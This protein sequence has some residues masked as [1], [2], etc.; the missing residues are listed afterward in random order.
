[1]WSLFGPVSK[2]TYYRHRNV[3][4]S[5]LQNRADENKEPDTSDI[6][7]LLDIESDH[8][9]DRSEMENIDLDQ[10]EYLFE[11]ALVMEDPHTDSD[12]DAVNDNHLVPFDMRPIS[13]AIPNAASVAEVSLALI[14]L[15]RKF[16]ISVAA[17]RCFSEL[18][19]IATGEG[20]R[21]PTFT[22]ARAVQEDSDVNY[23]VVDCCV[24]DDCVFENAPKHCDPN[25]LRQHRDLRKC[26]V[27]SESRYVLVG[28]DKGAARKQITVFSLQDTIKLLAQPGF[29]NARLGQRHP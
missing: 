20:S 6:A 5:G 17:M 24:N 13:D 9:S 25:K 15:Q 8:D 23:R 12:V 16:K 14:E 2:A 1:M 11:D 21:S 3:V 29:S 27:C 4:I 28:P 26:P 19:Q 7:Q 22:E 10:F 18:L